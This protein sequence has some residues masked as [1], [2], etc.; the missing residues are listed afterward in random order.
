MKKVLIKLLKSSN[1]NMVGIDVGLSTIKVMEVSGSSLEDVVLEGYATV[2]IPQDLIDENGRYKEE[3]ISIISKLVHK[4]WKKAGCTS[5]NVTICIKSNNVI[6]KKAI[7]PN[8][9]EK[10]DLKTAIEAEMS[11]Y[12]T[13]DISIED[14]AIDYCK[15]AD[16][17]LNPN[18]SEM[19]LIASKKDAIEELQAIIEGAGLEADILD[20]ETF[21]FQNLLRLMKDE[22]FLTGTY[23]LA[24]CA[25]SILRMFA[26]VN[27]NLVGTKE[28]QIGG[29]NLTQD[30]V[31]NL[32]VS[33]DVAEKMKI[34]RSGDETYDLIEKSFV[35]NYKTEFLSILSYFTSA[36]SLGDI[37]EV[38]LTGGVASIPFLE[39]AII[40]G[41]LES[42]DVDVKSEPYVARPLENA[43]KSKAINIAKFTEDEPGLFLVTSLAL[44][45]YLR[46]F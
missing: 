42:L 30:L 37:D 3:G 46:K 34:E 25:A 12:I 23:I 10:D 22:D 32:G 36:I 33:F 2:P 45:K 8:F 20:V 19:L 35:N 4:C 38:I 40:E 15:I 44:R 11:K 1:N 5:K 7:I 16:S 26:F 27:G 9:A 39:K 41:L 18:E 43:G 28:T 29:L 21:A 17:E 31:N 14:L 24:D 13:N 6:T